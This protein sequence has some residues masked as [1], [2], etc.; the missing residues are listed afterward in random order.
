M[1]NSILLLALSA[2]AILVGLFL[3]FGN[4]MNKMHTDMPKM[5]MDARAQAIVKDVIV[6]ELTAIERVGERKFNDNCAACHGANGGGTEGLAPPFI[7]KV[8]EP[9][10][11][12][13]IAFQ[14]AAKQGVRQHHWPF[15]NMP[16]IPSVSQR[17]VTEITAYIRALQRA[18]GI[19]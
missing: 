1:K 16:P 7:H 11:H 2:I 9:N 13:D 5:S 12:G 4:S 8:Y 6:P 18:N 19:Y 10:H 17:D 14:L 3:W 15:G